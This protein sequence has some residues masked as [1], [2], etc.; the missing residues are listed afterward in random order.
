MNGKDASYSIPTPPRPPRKQKG[1]PHDRYQCSPGVGPRP[2]MT[3]VL[4]W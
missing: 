3:H 1:K 4:H 2:E